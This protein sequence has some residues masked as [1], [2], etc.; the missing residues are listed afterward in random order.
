M[1]FAFG[2]VG[3][4]LAFWILAVRAEK[5]ASLPPDKVQSWAFQWTFVR[6]LIYALVLYRAYRLDQESL[7][8]LFAAVAGLFIIR[9]V[10]IFV[11]LTG[12]DLEKS[13]V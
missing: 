8:G 9:I 12:L 4:T 3:G 7:Y 11:A 2:G 10:M 1:G 5:L 6:L 13:K